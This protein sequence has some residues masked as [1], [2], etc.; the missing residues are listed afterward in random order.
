MIVFRAH[1]SQYIL[2][3]WSSPHKWWWGLLHG[4]KLFGKLARTSKPVERVISCPSPEENCQ[5]KIYPFLRR[6]GCH[7]FSN[8]LPSV[9]VICGV[10]LN[11]GGNGKMAVLCGVWLVP[12][13]F[14]GKLLGNMS[15]GYFER[16]QTKNPIS[17]PSDIIGCQ[18]MVHK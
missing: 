3:I 1:T 5:I 14:K 12:T 6:F 2:F 18:P 17:S 7:N 9:T 13:R 10:L 11:L 15:H 4:K 16:P 8:D